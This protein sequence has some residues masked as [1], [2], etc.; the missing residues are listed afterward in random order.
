MASAKTGF[1]SAFGALLGGA[2]GAYAGKLAATHRPV[3]RYGF[4]ARGRGAEVEDAMV[5]GGAAG[6]VVGAFIGGAASG[7]DKPA[8][9]QLK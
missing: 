4:R 8:T 9:P 1:W 5:V 6:A 7:E 3:Y 2:A